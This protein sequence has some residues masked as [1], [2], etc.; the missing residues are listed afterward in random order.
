[1]TGTSTSLGPDTRIG[2]LDFIR[3]IA[4]LGIFVLNIENFAFDG[5]FSPWRS[6]YA[7]ELDHTFRFWTYF[8]F[9]GKFFS[10]FALLF[11]VGFYL[12]LERAGRYGRAAVDLYAHRMFWLFVIGVLHAYLLWPGD[13]LYHYAVCGLLLL[14]ARSL[15]IRSL[16]LCVAA[17]AGLVAWQAIDAT[18]Q[19]RERQSAYE[20]ARVVPEPQRS[21]AE[22]DTVDRW[23]R[24]YTIKAPEAPDPD[25]PRLGGYLDNV[26]ANI[27][28]VGVGQGEIFYRVILFR[29]LMLMLAGI[30]LYRLGLFRDT[31]AIPGY[32]LITVA[33]LALGLAASYSR[34]WAWTFEYFRPVTSTGLALAHAFSRELLALGYLFLFNG[35]YQRFLMQR[36][37][38]PLSSVGRLALSNYLFQSIVA[39]FL[40]NG[41]GLG[42]HGQ[43]VRSELWPL[44]LAVWAV[45]LV[46][47]VL[48]LRRFRQGPMEALWRR[49]MLWSA[50]VDVGDTGSAGDVEGVRSKD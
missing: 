12:F 31:R 48:W 44:V 37:N 2:S 33:L 4:V 36:A 6:G 32:R 46:A 35:V 29:T 15:R 49:L 1:M 20:A 3:G 5:P 30:L 39:G 22:Q 23:E 43:L 7:G 50:R 16:A 47:S 13:I 27:D 24:R 9:Q 45:Q 19:L 42:L 28:A 26:A 14:P 17:L 25:S 8:L 21:D 40:F 10:L 18:A 11:G 38:D 34:N 41:Y